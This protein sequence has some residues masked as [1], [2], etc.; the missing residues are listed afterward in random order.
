MLTPLNNKR[1]LLLPAP[2]MYLQTS[3]QD[4][5]FSVE[6]D[7]LFLLPGEEREVTV[8]FSPKNITSTQR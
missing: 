4:S 7:D 6:P 8:K 1:F 2:R 5:C 3:E